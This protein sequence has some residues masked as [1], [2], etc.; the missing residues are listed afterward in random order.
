MM[1]PVYPR[2][3]DVHVNKR[4]HYDGRLIVVLVPIVMIVTPLAMSFA[5]VTI[6]FILVPPLGAE[7]N[8]T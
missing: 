6:V 4:T 5:I 7:V 2:P 1:V 3:N 8:P